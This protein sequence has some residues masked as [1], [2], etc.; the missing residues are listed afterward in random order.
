M[1]PKLLISSRLKGKQEQEKP[2]TAAGPTACATGAT[3]T[4]TGSGFVFL[5][6]D[7][8]LRTPAGAGA[9]LTAPLGSTTSDRS[10]PCAWG[11]ATGRAWLCVCAAGC[12]RGIV[13]GRVAGAATGLLRMSV[14][15]D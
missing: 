7:A 1:S 8:S 12:A 13:T 11:A 4:A 15:V 10:F 2:R 3:A 5:T 6:T 14:M 9:W